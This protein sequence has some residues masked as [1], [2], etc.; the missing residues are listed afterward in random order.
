METTIEDFLKSKG[1]K[2]K[3][4]LKVKVCATPPNEVITVVDKTGEGLIYTGEYKK[5]DKADKLKTGTYLKIFNPELKDEKIHITGKT[6]LFMI[7][8]CDTVKEEKVKMPKDD[9]LKRIASSDPGMVS[10]ELSVFK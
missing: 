8:K 4:A 5:K 1:E 2:K 6:M 10:I 9:T 7:A 3:F